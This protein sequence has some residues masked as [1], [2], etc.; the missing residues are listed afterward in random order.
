LALDPQ[1][2]IYITGPFKDLAANLTDIYTMKYNS[3]GVGLIFEKYNGTGSSYD[4]PAKI[5]LNN[6]NEIFAGG[7]SY[8]S[9]TNYDLVLIK[10][11]QPPHYAPYSFTA[12]AVSSSRI[13]LVWSDINNNETGFKIERSSNGGA[14]WIL[15]DSVA[16][17]TLHYSDLGLAANTIYS[18]RIYAYSPQ[19]QSVYSPVAYDTT[20]ATTGIVQTN[21]IPAV[22]KLYDNYP[23]PFNP[24]TTILFHI[25]LSRGVSA[26][27]DGRQEGRGVLTSLVIYDLLGREVKT[28]INQNLQPGK[29]SV[30]FDGGNLASG[31]YF[32]RLVS[33]SFTDIKKMLMIK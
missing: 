10:Y 27:P 19:G 17:D 23:N 22:Y 28:L 8:G 16:A 32:Y 7:S 33:G 13:N 3:S 20:F 25:P 14:N 31:V 30:S 6:Q 24:S 18:Y 12:T 11:I 1:G 29:Y 21:E 9:G 26:M 5:V 4:E 2:N 15:R